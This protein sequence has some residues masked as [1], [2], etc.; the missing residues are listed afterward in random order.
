MKEE[1]TQ[2]GN[3]ENE[4]DSENEPKISINTRDTVFLSMDGRKFIKEKKK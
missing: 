2:E 3:E 1:Q 4:E